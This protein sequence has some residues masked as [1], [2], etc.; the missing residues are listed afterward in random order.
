MCPNDMN[1]REF[2]ATRLRDAAFPNARS[3]GTLRPDHRVDHGPDLLSGLRP[4]RRADEIQRPFAQ[5]SE[6]NVRQGPD[7]LERNLP[8]FDRLSEQ[9]L[10]KPCGRHSPTSAAKGLAGTEKK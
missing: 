3:G 6:Q 4:V 1:L 5:R 9:L 8:S 10:R 2:G 7:R